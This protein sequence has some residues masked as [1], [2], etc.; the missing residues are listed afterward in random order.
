MIKVKIKLQRPEDLTMLN[1]AAA[2]MP[3]DIDVSSGWYLADAK[4]LVGLFGL[5][6]SEPVKVKMYTDWKGAE[7]FLQSIRG[8]IV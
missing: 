1:A 3:F 2:A 4:S 7:P 8:M 6:L 5:K